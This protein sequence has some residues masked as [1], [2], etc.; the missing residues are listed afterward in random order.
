MRSVLEQQQHA[1]LRTRAPSA[2]LR[3]DRL[4]RCITLLLEHKD[5]LI[6]ALDADFGARSKDMSVFT[7]IV[8]AIAPLKSARS[9]LDGWMKMQKRKVT[10]GAL[11]ILGAKAEV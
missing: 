6:D 2:A 8:A 7:D 11:A 4:T 5:Q 9:H 1:Q 10:P 3:K